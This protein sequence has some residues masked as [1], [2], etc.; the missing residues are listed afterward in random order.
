M[1]AR[2]KESWYPAFLHCVYLLLAYSF[3]S[4]SPAEVY[5]QLAAWSTSS[6]IS[7]PFAA[8]L[9]VGPCTLALRS[10]SRLLLDQVLR[11][12]ACPRLATA[13]AQATV[14]WLDLGDVPLP[15][16]PWPPQQHSAEQET[17]EYRGEGYLFTRH[18]DVLLTA[19]DEHNGHTVAL[20]HA[21]ARWPLRHYKQGI[22][23]TLYQL[24]RG[25]GLH[26]IHASA[27]G[28]D[29]RALLIA[30][31]SGAGKTTTMLT[32]V[33]AGYQFLGDDTTLLWLDPAGT[34]QVAALLSTLDVTD[35][36]AAWFPQL[37]PFL[38]P[39]RNHTGKRQ[40]ILSEAFPQRVAA[41]A[42]VVAL[43][44]PMVTGAV[45]TTLTPL[46]KATLLNDLLFFSV[47]LQDPAFTRRHV[48]FLAQL[49]EQ[50]PVYLLR[51]GSEREDVL[52]AIADALA[53]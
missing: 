53:E 28:R 23:I 16:L 48:E 1:L 7:S 34:V 19:L 4:S 41:Q 49:V 3:S 13:T 45:T 35:K 52:R 47:D 18:G 15:E 50:N 22:F 27:I 12:L 43:L 14:D 24:L 51:L 9:Q 36:T 38:S 10:S 26:L 11:P 29:G 25:H 21:P 39:Q 33:D 17:S 42:Q 32:C 37:A 5:R 40:I 6:L 2:E 46:N 20:V 30:G 44:M 8:A 31:R